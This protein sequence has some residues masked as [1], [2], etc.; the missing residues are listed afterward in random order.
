MR[1]RIPPRSTK[2]RKVIMLTADERKKMLTMYERRTHY[3]ADSRRV[4]LVVVDQDISFARCRG[5]VALESL[6]RFDNINTA[7]ISTSIRNVHDRL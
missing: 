1:V 5:S 3:I 7:E 4:P 6:N 2:T